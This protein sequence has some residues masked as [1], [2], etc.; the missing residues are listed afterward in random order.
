MAKTSTTCAECGRAVWDTDV[1][2]KGKCILCDPAKE[3]KTPAPKKKPAPK[4]TDPAPAESTAAV[5]GDV[6]DGSGPDA[7]GAAEPDPSIQ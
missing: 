7:G 1:N 3:P 4:A 2:S 5:A 6:A